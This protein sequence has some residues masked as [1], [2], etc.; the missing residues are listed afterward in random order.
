MALVGGREVHPVNVRVGGF[1]RAP[2]ARASCARSSTPLERARETAL[3]T[4]RWAAALAVPRRRAAS[5][6]LR[7]AARRRRAIRSTA[8]AIV[9]D[10]GL[11]IA[12]AEFDEHVVEEHVEH[13]NALHA[14]PARARHLPGRPARALQPRVRRAA[15]RSRARR[16]ATAGLG[17]ALPQPVP[18]HRRAR[19]RAGPGV[20]RGARDHRRLRASPTRRPSRSSRAARRRARRHRG[21]ARPALPPLRDR[22]GRHDP[23][24]A[25]RPA[26]LAEPARDRGGPARRRRAP[27]R[28]RRRAAA[29]R[30]EQAIRNHDPCISCATHFL[31]LTVD[32]G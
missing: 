31:E 25:D 13:S 2:D 11:D 10:R 8:G 9:S 5:H 24:R 4:V 26:D 12:A 15:R 6:E 21:A 14:Q 17:P 27:R 18:E 29:L 1:Y 28:P 19:R 23:R 20:R 32:R 3:A 16:R 22:R 30:C 7:R